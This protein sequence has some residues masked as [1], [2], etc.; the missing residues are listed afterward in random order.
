MTLEKTPKQT[1]RVNVS[2]LESVQE[3]AAKVMQARLKGDNFSE[4]VRDLIIEEYKRPETAAKAELEWLSR[5]FREALTE[6]AKLKEENGKT[7]DALK[8]WKSSHRTMVDMGAKYKSAFEE[9]NAKLDAAQK[10]ADPF[11]PIRNR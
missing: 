8:R 10:V 11:P 9:A 2:L 7:Q 4:L 3:I 5:A 6:N 1:E